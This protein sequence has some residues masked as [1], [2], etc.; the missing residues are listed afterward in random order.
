M[1]G[2]QKS[3]RIPKEILREIGQIAEERQKD[4]SSVANELLEEA[5]KTHRCPGIIF[6]EGVKGR[7]A[8][9]AGT[10]I[11]VWEVVAAFKS[12]GERL[13]RLRKSYHWLTEQQIQSALGYYKVYS[14]EID[15]LISVNESW[16]PERVQ[17]KYPFLPA[18]KQ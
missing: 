8:R 9:V 10:G 13:E 16:N 4:F 3:L 5:V 2:I 12:V 1:A 17:K 11:E 14:E 15:H 7:R 18:G 6:T